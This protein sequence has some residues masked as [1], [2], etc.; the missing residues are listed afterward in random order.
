MTHAIARHF[1]EGTKVTQPAGGFVLWVELPDKVDALDL[2]RRALAKKINIAPGPLFSAKQKYRNFIRLTCAIPW[3]ERV[4][5]ALA[6]LG[7]LAAEMA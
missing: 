5:R 1:P 6:T 2:H 7:R 4:E 3:D